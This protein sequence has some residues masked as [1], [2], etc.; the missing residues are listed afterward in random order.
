MKPLYTDAST[1]TYDETGGAGMSGAAYPSTVSQTAMDAANDAIDTIQST[2][3]SATTTIPAL[4]TTDRTG[5]RDKGEL[6]DPTEK[7]SQDQMNFVAGKSLVTSEQ[8]QYWAL[9]PASQS[10]LLRAANTMGINFMVFST[11]RIQGHEAY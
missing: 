11:T 8:S 7:C 6:C 10:V 9:C 2:A 5:S 3:D 1:Q 4:T